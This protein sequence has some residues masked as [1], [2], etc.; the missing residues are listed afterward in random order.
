MTLVEQYPPGHV[1]AA[2]GGESRLIRF[3]H[4]ENAWYTS[5]SRRALDLWRELER[6]TGTELFVPSGVAW[7]FSGAH[8]WGD[9]SE[10]V[11]NEHGIAAERLEPGDGARLFPSFDGSGLASI[12][13]EPEA[14]VLRAR[15]ATRAI[16]E[17]A[18]E[19]GV[20]FVTGRA[21]PDGNAVLVGGERHEADHVVWA[22]GAWLATIFPDVVDL[23]VTRQDVYFFGAPAGWQAPDVP[24]WVDFDN[25]VY[26]VGELDGRGFKASPDREGPA[27][28]PD[29]GERVASQE[30]E[31]EARDYLALRFP[32]LAEAPLVGTRS[33]PYSL[34]VDTNFLIAPH[35]EHDRV[36]LFGGGSGH[37]FKHGP[38]LAE[39]ME[40]LLNG[41]DEP[42]EAFGLGARAPG[43]GLRAP[44]IER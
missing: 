19:R 10:R 18:I 13:Y 14:G 41:E 17:L 40:R 3:S 44:W 20:R 22:G 12:L 7:F 6:D 38:A 28:D 24:A 27:F 11:L 36:W 43:G 2:S 5:S 25:G 30:K 16:S 31:R 39:Y 32:D 9:E 34:T 42:G 33:C 15:D 35:P 1:R 23:R 29:T 37:G 8:G 21:A 4:G 26:G